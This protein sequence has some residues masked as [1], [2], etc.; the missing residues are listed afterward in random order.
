MHNLIQLHQ[1]YVSCIPTNMFIPMAY[2]NYG[3]AP[4]ANGTNP[5]DWMAANWAWNATGFNAANRL[6]QGLTVLSDQDALYYISS[7]YTDAT[8]VA[9]QSSWLQ[10]GTEEYQLVPGSF[11]QSAAATVNSSAFCTRWRNI[12]GMLQT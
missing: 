6:T 9:C 3:K 11:A 2:F 1:I 10:V 8:H 7:T 4:G 12:A 5:E